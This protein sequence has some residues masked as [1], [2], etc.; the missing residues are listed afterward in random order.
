M[1]G[2]SAG[3]R[4]PTARWSKSIAFG[5]LVLLTCLLTAGFALFVWSRFETPDRI[6]FRIQNFA[7]YFAIWRL[8]TITMVIAFWRPLCERIA[9]WRDLADYELHTLLAH[10]WTLAVV[11]LLTELIVVQRLPLAVAAGLG[12]E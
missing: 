7:P 4:K 6:A 9:R 12:G 5:T 8:A 2:S 3:L 11:L 10:R 1:N